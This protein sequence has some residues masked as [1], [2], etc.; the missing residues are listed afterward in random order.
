[1]PWYQVAAIV[2]SGIAALFT[3]IK[4][5]SAGFRTAVDGVMDQQMREV[6]RSIDE[7][8]KQNAHRFASVPPSR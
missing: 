7:L 5:V 1:M 6:N 3:V 8:D 2:L 4:F